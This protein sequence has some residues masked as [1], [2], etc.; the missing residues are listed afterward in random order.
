MAIQAALKFW[1]EFSV[2]DFQRELDRQATEIAKKQ[3]DSDASRKKLIELSRDFKKNS[4]EEVRRKASPLLKS[5]QAEIDALS[6]RSQAAEAA[7]LSTYKR[8]IEI[9]DP[10][11]VLEQAVG[12]QQRLQ[13]AQDHELQNSKLRETLEEYKTEFAQVKNQEV[14]I[15][16]LREQLKKMEQDQEQKMAVKKDY[17]PPTLY[18]NNDAYNMSC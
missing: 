17:V 14:T 11:P 6:R 1:R 18:A 3:D 10:T 8:A 9:P 12:V 5:F 16:R 2:Q 7:F 13:S 15:N 4:T